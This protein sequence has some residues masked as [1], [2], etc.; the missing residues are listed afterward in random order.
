MRAATRQTHVLFVR[1][2]SSPVSFRLQRYE[3]AR[4]KR[5]RED[6][7]LCKIKTEGRSQFENETKDASSERKTYLSSQDPILSLSSSF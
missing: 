6:H 7:E 2:R 3:Q 1:R 5:R 4:G